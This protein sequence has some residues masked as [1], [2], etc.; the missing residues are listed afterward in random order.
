MCI[1]LKANTIARSLNHSLYFLNHK[2]QI[3]EVEV[4]QPSDLIS[5]IATKRLILENYFFQI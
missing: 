5:L 3:F 2:R 4:L 1:S